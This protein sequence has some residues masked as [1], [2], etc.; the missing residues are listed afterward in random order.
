MKKKRHQRWKRILKLLQNPLS[1]V[2]ISLIF[3]FWGGI[4]KDYFLPKIFDTPK[5]SI[6]ANV[7]SPS[8]ISVE[9]VNANTGEKYPV[10]GGF[11][12]PIYVSFQNTG[13][14]PL[15]DIKLNIDFITDK[16][17]F[18][19]QEEGY[20]TKPPKGFGNV[21]IEKNGNQRIIQIPLFNPGEILIYEAFG[22]Y[23]VKTQTYTKT[24]GLSFFSEVSPSCNF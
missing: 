23:P 20:I 5:Y 2:L 10:K 11:P 12:V 7:C 15:V 3:G 1:L 22:N 6:K 4:I 9:L 13:K 21:Q 24:S 8:E 17:D 16:T 18:K 14:E 19:L